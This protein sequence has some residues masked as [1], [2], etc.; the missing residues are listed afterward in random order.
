VPIGSHVEPCN[1]A[2]SASAEAKML[3]T[4]ACATRARVA[5]TNISTTEGY[6]QSHETPLSVIH[7]TSAEQK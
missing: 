2:D 5:H 4:Y 7:M 3:T 6:L 1:R